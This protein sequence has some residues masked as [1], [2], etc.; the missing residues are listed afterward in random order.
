L[1]GLSEAEILDVILAAAAPAFLSKV[2]SAVGA[3]PDP[4]V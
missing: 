3:D 4:G 1:L 2:L